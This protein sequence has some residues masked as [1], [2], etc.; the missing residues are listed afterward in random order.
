MLG[1]PCVAADRSRL[2]L[3][4]DGVTADQARGRRR[5]RSRHDH[6]R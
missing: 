2:A 1:L 6:G 4:A 3:I 5:H